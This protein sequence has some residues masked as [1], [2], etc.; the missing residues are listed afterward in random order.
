MT[1]LQELLRA[2]DGATVLLPPA[3]AV[4]LLQELAGE[5]QQ[6]IYGLHLELENGDD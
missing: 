5:V 4:R 6:R 2:I 1:T 3:E